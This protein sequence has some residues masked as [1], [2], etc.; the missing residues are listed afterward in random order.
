MKERQARNL[1]GGKWLSKFYLIAG[2]TIDAIA[3][4][5]PLKVPDPE[6]R[7]PKDLFV[8]SVIPRLYRV[9][10]GVKLTEFSS[11][12]AFEGFAH[13][14]VLVSSYDDAMDKNRDRAVKLRDLKLNPVH[15]RIL[16][17]SIRIIRASPSDT[18]DKEKFLKELAEF[19]RE[20]FKMYQEFS[21]P[22][23]ERTFL[24]V[25]DYKERTC[26]LNARMAARFLRLFTPQIPDSEARK[27][28]E[29]VTSVLRFAQVYD[30]IGDLLVDMH[31]DTPNY[32]SAALYAR[33]TEKQTMLSAIKSGVLELA[34][35][36]PLAPNSFRVCASAAEEYI[37]AIPQDYNYLK[38]QIALVKNL[39]A[40]R[41]NPVPE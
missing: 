11:T 15:Q 19:R 21:G 28:E 34:E 13:L 22:V 2:T 25:K 8:L 38:D 17:D 23:Q 20:E 40:A 27:A 6:K 14:Y 41:I 9:A 37:S 24:E 26:G 16:S 7:K 33:P 32:L 36:E 5:R 35:L 18:A 3:Y 1:E 30:D 12:Q 29:L 31:Y 10:V 4:A 39:M